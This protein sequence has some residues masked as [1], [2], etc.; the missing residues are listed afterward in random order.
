MYRIK[1]KYF[2]LFL[3]AVVTSNSTFSQFRD[4]QVN[5]MLQQVYGSVAFLQRQYNGTNLIAENVFRLKEAPDNWQ[6]ALKVSPVKEYSDAID[7]VATFRLTAGQV[8]A[9]TVAMKFD[10]SNWSPANY[11]L[12]PASL[13][14]GNRYRA[15]GN[16]YN[17]DYPRDMYYN[18]QVPLTISNNPRLS[19]ENDQASLVELQ[20]GSMATPAVCFFSPAE[21]MGFILLTTQQTKWGNNGVTIT[22]SAHKDHFSFDLSAPAMRK[23]AAGFG[24]FHLSGD[25]A[26]DWKAGDEVSL[27]F[28]L[29]VFKA[30]DIPALLTKF[31]KVRKDI[32]DHAAP[33]NLVPM[34]KLLELGT[35]ICSSNFTQQQ[36]GNYYKPENSN[37]FQLGWVSGMINTYPMLSLNDEKERKRVCEE[38]DFVV[39]RLQGKSGY[40]YGGIKANGEITG[41]KMSRD[42]PEV[43]ALVRKNGDALFWLMKHLLLFRESGHAAMINKDWEEAAKRLAGAFVKTWQKHGQFGQYIAPETG[44]VAVFNSTAGA[45]VPAGMA[46]AANYF[47]RADWLQTAAASADYYYRRDVAGQGLTGGDCGDISQD[48]NSESAFGFLES[49]MALY[50]YTG[51]HKWL[52]MAEVQAA[53]CSSWTL[54]Y[55]PVFP[56]SS[57][58]GKLQANMTGAVWASI[59]NKHAAPGICTSS[60]DYL[61]KLFRATGK[62]LYADLIRDIQHAHTEAVNMPGHITSNYLVGSSMERIQPGDAEG[63]ESTGN[64]IY[65]RN[66]WTETNGMLMALELPGIY[67]IS[68][69]SK[70]YVFDHVETTI[71]KKDNKGLVI[72]L[73]NPTA[74]DASVTVMSETSLEAK[75]PMGYTA[76]LR[77]P[78]VLVKAGGKARVSISGKEVRCL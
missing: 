56:P 31:F 36:A 24:D 5:R 48:A 53:L 51:D 30:P 34:S 62:S 55:A 52:S 15:I 20:T 74:Y 78:K 71:I 43:Q 38:L 17:P 44:E 54:S 75:Q 72:L 18:P 57:T 68:D 73:H 25:K 12:V 65:T 59:Q 9:A 4:P 2:L 32:P 21:Q 58:I 49:L 19:I 64:F 63:K 70:C 6:L 61:F 46:L 10:F 45:I 7:V 77:W 1:I 22:E 60:G 11:V 8:N 42:F 50:K 14:N 66:S 37:D 67:V 13:Y 41:E 33:R 28:R 40:F 26:P 39:H 23:L 3:V 16:G 76:F 35:G 47:N 27:R 69:K 29:Y